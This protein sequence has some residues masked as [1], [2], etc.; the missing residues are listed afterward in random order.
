[1][2]AKDQSSR[3]HPRPR[4]WGGFIQ[5]PTFEKLSKPERPEERLPNGLQAYLL[6]G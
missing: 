2:G 5:V 3:A 4:D 6:V 1:M